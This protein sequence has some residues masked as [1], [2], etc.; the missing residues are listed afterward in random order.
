MFGDCKED[1]VLIEDN[2]ISGILR[3][4]IGNVGID[5]LVKTD[6]TWIWTKM[7]SHCP[8]LTGVR[9]IFFNELVI[10]K[11]SDRKNV[12]YVGSPLSLGAW[13]FF[14]CAHWENILMGFEKFLGIKIPQSFWMICI[15]WIQRDLQ[16][17]EFILSKSS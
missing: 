5:V 2:M 7:L 3:E 15:R 11:K 8:W 14:L 16:G 9:T 4:K 6:M 13:K 17:K 12:E 10:Q 1:V